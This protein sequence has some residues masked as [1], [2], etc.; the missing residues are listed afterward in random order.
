MRI[1]NTALSCVYS[2]TKSS[3]LCLDDALYAE[4]IVVGDDTDAAVAV[5]QQL[6]D[7]HRL[8]FL[9]LVRF[10]QLFAR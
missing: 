3:S 1:H 4:A 5:I 8:V 10:L 7:L 9:Y 6:P 2:V